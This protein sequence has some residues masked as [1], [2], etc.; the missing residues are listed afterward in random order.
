[1]KVVFV[2]QEGGISILHP[3]LTEG[4][5]L[6]HVIKKDI[7]EGVQYWVVNDD[8]IPTDRHFRDA[9]EVNTRKNASQR[10]KVNMEKAIEI[11]RNNIR[12]ERNAELK[13]LDTEFMKAL[14]KGDSALANSIAEKN[15]CCATLRPALFLRHARH[16]K[17]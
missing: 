3:V 7:P 16:K 6:E 5:T 4:L 17:N 12:R 10:I 2:N 1:M 8:D 11:Q 9:W 13:R 14:E 15:K